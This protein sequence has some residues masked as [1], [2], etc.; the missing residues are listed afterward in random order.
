MSR[1]GIRKTREDRIV[2]F[3]VYFLAI[4]VFLVTFYPFYLSIVL[5]FNEGRDALKG[6]I[7]LWP[8]TPTLENFAELIRD[9]SWA[10]ALLVTVARTGLGTVV[11]VFFTSLM[12]YGLS[13]RELKGR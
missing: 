10:Q 11:T 5:A 2:D 9:R 6:G 4:I 12:S 8:R 7:Y 1:T 13:Y 3:V